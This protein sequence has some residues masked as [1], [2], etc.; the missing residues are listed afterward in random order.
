MGAMEGQDALPILYVNG[1]RRVMPPG[2][3]EVTL[4]AYLRGA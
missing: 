3:A 1:K 4:L 2:Q